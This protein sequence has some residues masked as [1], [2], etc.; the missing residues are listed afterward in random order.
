MCVSYVPLCA[1]IRNFWYNFSL[2]RWMHENVFPFLFRPLFGFVVCGSV[3]KFLACICAIGSSF[4]L[5]VLQKQCSLLLMVFACSL[6]LCVSSVRVCSCFATI[7][8]DISWWYCSS[9]NDRSLLH[10]FWVFVALFRLFIHVAVH[11]LRFY[12]SVETSFA[13]VGFALSNWIEFGF[14]LYTISS[15]LLFNHCRYTLQERLNVQHAPLNTIRSFSLSLYKTFDD[16]LLRYAAIL[17]FM[18]SQKCKA[19]AFF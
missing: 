18:R 4:A 10:L 16:C 2:A 19:T 12:L 11:S 9:L 14:C 13:L 1:C 7:T 3:P 17:A 6:F 15:R 8:F 5:S